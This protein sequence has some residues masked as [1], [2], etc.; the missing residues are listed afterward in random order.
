MPTRHDRDNLERMGD[1]RWTLSLYLT[2]NMLPQDHLSN[3]F[4]NY[5]QSVKRSYCQQYRSCAYPEP[6]AK[7][8]HRSK[9]LLVRLQAPLQVRSC[10]V[11]NFHKSPGLSPTSYLRDLLFSVEGLSVAS[12][13]WRW[14]LVSLLLVA[15][16]PSELHR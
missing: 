15:V 16:T 6:S 10:S 1:S 9:H 2:P 7:S 5:L 8:Q 11:C 4:S 12:H 3:T 13:G 14:T